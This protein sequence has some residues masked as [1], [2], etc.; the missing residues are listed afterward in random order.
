MREIITT[1]TLT[2]A[3]VCAVG[4]YVPE[5]SAG[6]NL[7]DLLD[8]RVLTKF[9][10]DARAKDPERRSPKWLPRNTNWAKMFY[11][12]YGARI[13][14]HWL[15]VGNPEYKV[16]HKFAMI[17]PQYARSIRKYRVLNKEV[18]VEVL[19]PHPRYL[20]MADFNLVKAFG[21]MEPPKL[22]VEYSEDLIIKNLDAKLHY[23]PDSQCSILIKLNRASRINFSAPCDDLQEMTDLAED[24]SYSRFQHKLDT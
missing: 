3:L 24:M 7:Q 9:E 13:I 23:K 5:A 17:H 22:E 14:H 19:V 11:T 1:F 15:D 4:S 8:S 2:V 12:S 16:T 10:T 6:D 18:Q 21:E 20:E